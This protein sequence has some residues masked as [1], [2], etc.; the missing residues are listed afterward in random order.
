MATP[1]PLTW[2][3][4]LKSHRTTVLLHTDPLASFLTLKTALYSALTDTGLHASS[5][6]SPAI[7][8]PASPADIKLARPIDPLDPSAGFVLGE[9]ETGFRTSGSASDDEVAVDEEEMGGAQAKGKGKGKA[10]AEMAGG[11]DCPKGAGLKDGG[12]LAFRWEGDG[13]VEAEGEGDKSWGVQIARFEDAY[14]VVN[15]GDVGARGEFE[16]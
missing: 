7:P 15:E 5:P 10:K 8:L 6:A 4:R 11:A 14:G 16:G 13:V 1:T 3:L 12:V 2:T 9:W